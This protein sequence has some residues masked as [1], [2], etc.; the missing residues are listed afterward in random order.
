MLSY[1]V[2]HMNH[3]NQNMSNINNDGEEDII[4]ARDLPTLYGDLFDGLNA[5]QIME[6]LEDEDWSE[7][8]SAMMIIL[9]IVYVYVKQ[10]LCIKGQIGRG[11][12]VC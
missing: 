4:V 5:Y 3:Q 6:L 1:L 2:H 9:R 10:N 11:M 7:D 8:L 12:H